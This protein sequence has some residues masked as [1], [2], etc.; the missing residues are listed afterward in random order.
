MTFS[1]ETLMAYADGELEAATRAAVEAAM[2]AD[3]EVARRIAQHQALRARLRSAFDP[4]LAEPPPERLL[5]AA[6]G[7]A[8]QPLPGK[9]TALRRAGA[10]WSWPQWGALAASLVLGVLL[11][12]WLLRAPGGAPLITRD[13]TLLAAGTLAR[14]LSEQLASNQPASAAVQIG[15]SFRS[16]GGDYCRSFVLHEKSALAGLACRDHGAWRL[17]ALAASESAPGAGGAYRAAAAALPPAVAGTLDALIAGEPLDARA[18]A[19]AR[20]RGWKD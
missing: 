17:E 11:G 8:M 20:D 3:P 12:P 16:R 13:G 19:A 6:R 9:V 5:A 1:D 4:L 2:A 15:V 10:R 18:E 14:A 7:T